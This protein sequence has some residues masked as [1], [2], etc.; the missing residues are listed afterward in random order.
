LVQWSPNKFAGSAEGSIWEAF[1]KASYYR[2]S[3]LVAIVDVNRLGQRGETDLGWNLDVYA[4]RAQA[5]GARV[6]T[7]DGHDLKAIDDAFTTAEQVDDRPTVI[8]AMTIKG[9]GFSEVEDSPDWYRWGRAGMSIG[10]P[11]TTRT[12]PAGS[13]GCCWPAGRT[14]RSWTW[15]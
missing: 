15:P 3:N 4:A 7:I 9:K 12:W 1:D 2:L 5:F 6:L 11:R 10:R 14:T 8:L 13:G